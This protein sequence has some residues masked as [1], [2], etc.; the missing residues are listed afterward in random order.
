MS[1]ETPVISDGTE[2]YDAKTDDF[3]INHVI[4]LVLQILS[5]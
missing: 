1:R 3:L 5:I 2:S 4:Y